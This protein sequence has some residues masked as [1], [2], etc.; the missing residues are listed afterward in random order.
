MRSINPKV[1]E[2]DEELLSVLMFRFGPYWPVFLFLL[3]LS[4]IGAWFYLQHA[5]PMYEANATILIKDEKKGVDN[6]K[7]LESLD[8]YTSKKIVENEMEV[9]RSRSLMKEVV[10]KLKLYAPVYEEGRFK[11][12]NAYV[13]S[14]ITIEAKEPENL[15]KTE[16]VYFT[17]NKAKA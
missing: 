3:F 16:K 12:A 6:S 14:P 10:K 11:D 17:Y 2:K 1:E 7:M 13:S 5:R 8:I 9:L 4:L 15:K